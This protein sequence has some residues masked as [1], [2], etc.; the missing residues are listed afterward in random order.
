MKRY[1][2]PRSWRAYSPAPRPPAPDR[3]P[4]PD[5]R[6]LA[7]TPWAA[8][9]DASPA[10]RCAAAL[11]L[12]PIEAVRDDAATLDDLHAFCVAE[13]GGS[14][15]DAVSYMEETA[16]IVADAIASIE[17][18]AGPV[19]E[20]SEDVAAAEP[21][22]TVSKAPVVAPVPVLTLP[23]TDDRAVAGGSPPETSDRVTAVA[24]PTVSLDGAPTRGVAVVS[25]AP[26]NLSAP[27]GPRSR[28]PRR[29]PRRLQMIS[30]AGTFPGRRP[31]PRRRSLSQ[32]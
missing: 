30:R 3:A 11:R 5:P 21:P 32:D 13:R 20:P 28:R 9:A 15:S 24:P 26:A 23:M 12:R 19:A 4:A 14:L 25:K 22:G 6:P 18:A 27:D 17:P 16:Q 7:G 10:A 8:F 1:S 31:A 2:Q 29:A